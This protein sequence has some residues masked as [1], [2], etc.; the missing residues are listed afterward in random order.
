[1]GI[2]AEWKVEY[3]LRLKLRANVSMLRLSGCRARV[4]GDRI[5]ARLGCGGEMELGRRK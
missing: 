2:V 1:M 3:E 4:W 5:D